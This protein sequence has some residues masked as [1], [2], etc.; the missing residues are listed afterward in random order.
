MNDG[1]PGAG[2]AGCASALCSTALHC[3]AGCTLNAR[4]HG[5]TLPVGSQCVHHSVTAKEMNG[6]LNLWLY[7]ARWK[8]PF[9]NVCKL[10]VMTL[11]PCWQTACSYMYMYMHY[12]GW[13]CRSPFAFIFEVNFNR[14]DHSSLSYTYLCLY[15]SSEQSAELFPRNSEVPRRKFAASVYITTGTVHSLT[16]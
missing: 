14:I 16:R 11:W 2:P 10:T 8:S 1:F 13:T 6:L 3:T 5:L 4:L 9:W 12:V 15:R 7:F